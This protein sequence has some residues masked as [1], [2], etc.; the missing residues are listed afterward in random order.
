M[1][2]FKQF[3]K[4]DRKEP[5]VEAPPADLPARNDLCWCGRQI[6]YKKCHMEQDQIYLAQNKASSKS[7]RPVFG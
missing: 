6:K 5:A 3:F 1:N 2:L 4:K 7:C